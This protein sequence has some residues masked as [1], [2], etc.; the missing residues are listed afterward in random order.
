MLLPGGSQ[1]SDAQGRFVFQNLAAGTYRA[2][3]S[4]LGYVDGSYGGESR[5]DSRG[6][7]LTADQWVSDARI[8]L[9]RSAAIS[10]TVLDERGEPL[11]GAYVRA[12][13][14]VMIAGEPQFADS[15]F[16]R[17]DDR[18]E[19]RIWNLTAGAYAVVVLSV[20]QTSPP[21]SGPARASGTFPAPPPDADGRARVYPGMYYSTARTSTDASLIT[22]A[23]GEEKRGIDV[24]LQALPVRTIA[25]RVEGPGDA[26]GGLV[27]RLMV[28]GDEGLGPGAEVAATATATDGRFVL[29]NVP[30]GR[31][32]LQTTTTLSEWTVGGQSQSLTF[33][34]SPWTQ[35]F[36]LSRSSQAV[37][38]GYSV[39][40]REG[41]DAYWARVN[42]VVGDDDVNNLTVALHPATSLSGHVVFVDGTPDTGLL[43]VN[44]EPANGSIAL[45]LPGSAPTVLV[46]TDKAAAG[47]ARTSGERAYPFTIS[48]LMAGEYVLRVAPQPNTAL[49]SVTW[50][51]RDYTDMPF[52][53]AEG[54]DI[55]GVVVTLTDRIPKI[56]GFV[57]DGHGAPA[58]DAAVLYFPVRRDLWKK[59]GATPVR[60]GSV[61]TNGSG[62]YA[63][64]SSPKTSFLTMRMPAGDYYLVA[65]PGSQRSA[66]Q[67]PTFLEAASRVATMVTVGWG[68]TKTQDLILQDIRK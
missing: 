55:T 51:G 41:A 11:V 10:G 28:A 4:R 67:D 48:G 30:A 50:D 27:L 44:A 9:F 59:F 38:V 63:V 7:L 34:P 54:A 53:G 32:T 68:E 36:R 45:G 65:V 66:W 15:A 3:A 39:F 14:R 33:T 47:S 18:G 35:G 2:F 12:L 20:Q 29:M 40:S 25:G 61:G 24:R 31:Y 23:Y 21:E 43:T 62:A 26:V 46:G 6:I 16:T 22:L 49:K 58:A 64:N 42:V 56:A 52:D 8:S 17:S 13:A 1:V 57:R 60:L 19:Y 5:D 37:G